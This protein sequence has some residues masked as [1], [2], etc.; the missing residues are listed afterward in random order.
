MNIKEQISLAH[1][2]HA[3]LL[4]K[5]IVSNEVLIRPFDEP[6]EEEGVDI[7]WPGYSVSVTIEKDVFFITITAEYVFVPGDI[8]VID[9]PLSK[10][11]DPLSFMG[12]ECINAFECVNKRTLISDSFQSQLRNL[13]TKSNINNVKSFIDAGSAIKSILNSGEPEPSDISFENDIISFYSNNEKFIF[14]PK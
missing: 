6:G 7:D 8:D 14:Y 3:F 9:F 2:L 1:K 12:Q 10:E 5:E 11:D 13:D 4:Q